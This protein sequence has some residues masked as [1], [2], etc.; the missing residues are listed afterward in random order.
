MCEGRQVIPPCCHQLVLLTKN[1]HRHMAMIELRLFIAILLMY[2]SLEI[3]EG[4]MTRPEVVRERMGLGI[5]HPKGDI[6][7]ILRKRK[8]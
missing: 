4:C 7:V 2:G 1:T 8:L 6:D 5:V 3:D